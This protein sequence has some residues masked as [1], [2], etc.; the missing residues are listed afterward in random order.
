MHIGKCRHRHA[1]NTA[2]ASTGN[3]G[4]GVTS[5]D[6]FGGFTYSV[7]AGRARGDRREVW[8]AR[9]QAHGNI[10]G[11]HIRCDRGYEKGADALRALFEE[12]VKSILEY[13]QPTAA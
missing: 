9:L 10:A 8:A 12:G 2:L 7:R 11:C 5:P 4:L 13:L 1:G 3:H 6:D